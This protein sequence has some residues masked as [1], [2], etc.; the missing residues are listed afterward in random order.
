VFGVEQQP[1]KAGE[2]KNF[3]SDRARKRAPAADEAR[4]ERISRRNVLGKAGWDIRFRIQEKT[5]G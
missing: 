4:P 3:G 1:V 2:A 5:T